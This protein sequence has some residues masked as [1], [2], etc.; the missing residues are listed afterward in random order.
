M[1]SLQVTAINVI[2]YAAVSKPAM[3][4]A[5]SFSSMA[6]Q[7][8]ISI[9]VGLRFLHR[10]RRAQHPDDALGTLVRLSPQAG[11]DISGTAKPGDAK[12]VSP[13]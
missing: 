10:L 6:Q 9:G 1:R 12:T 8:A 7:L 4:R 11:S 2:T 3:S 5:T 13:R